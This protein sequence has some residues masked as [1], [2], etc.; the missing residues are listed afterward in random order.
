VRSAAIELVELE[1]G[2]TLPLPPLQHVPEAAGPPNGEGQQIE[3]VWVWD[4]DSEGGDSGGTM[5]YPIFV[6]PGVTAYYAA[7]L[8]V[9]STPD[10]CPEEEGPPNTCRSWYST[11]QQVQNPNITNGVQLTICTTEDC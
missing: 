9:H 11:A 6:M 7:G 1:P 4:H 3:L 10:D 2:E 5:I 8:H